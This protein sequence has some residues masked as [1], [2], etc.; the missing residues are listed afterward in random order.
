LAGGLVV[1]DRCRVAPGIVAAGDVTVR[2]DRAGRPVRR[3]HWTNAVEQG[4]AAALALLDENAEP[5]QPED[6][7]W[8]EQFGWDVK[9]MGRLPAPGELEILDG[10]E[11]SFLAVFSDGGRVCTAVAANYRIPRK[12]L[13]ALVPA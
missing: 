11:G 4:T 12:R 5:Y 1:D 9:V 7:F 6:Y 10:S 2:L 8:T 3:P 13:A